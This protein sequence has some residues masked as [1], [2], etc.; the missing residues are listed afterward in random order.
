MDL[1]VNNILSIIP[2]T[3]ILFNDNTGAMSRKSTNYITFVPE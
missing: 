1:I 2:Y 3:V